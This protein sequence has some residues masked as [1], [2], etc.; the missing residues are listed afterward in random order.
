MKDGYKVFDCDMH[1]HEPWDLWLNYI[2]DEFKDLNNM[3][4]SFQGKP[5]GQ[6]LVQAETET[7]TEV[8]EHEEEHARLGIQHERADKYLQDG[9]ERHF[10]PVSQ[11]KAMDVEGIDQAVLYP[12]RGMVVAGVDYEDDA[13]AGA[14][15]RAYNDW[16]A[17]FCSTDPVRMK[18]VAMILV[19]D[20][21]EAVR[22]TRRVR[23]ELDL[24]VFIYIPTQSGAATGMTPHTTRYGRNVRSKIWQSLFMKPS[25]VRC[26]WRWRIVS[27]MSRTKSGQWRTS[28]VTPLNRCMRV[29][30]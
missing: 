10:D 8:E 27:S 5:M 15:A 19:M 20:I 13:L 1:V 17:D 12:S 16:L 24:S 21:E 6:F 14:I 4:T 2:D 30:A 25:S 11:L 22:E 29:C 7:A 28:R 23:E 18:G 3:N 26:P 9:M